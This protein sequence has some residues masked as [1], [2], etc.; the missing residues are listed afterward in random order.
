M[1]APQGGLGLS[2][3]EGVSL[4]E[5]R[6]YEFSGYGSGGFFNGVSTHSCV[7]GDEA[8]GSNNRSIRARYIGA[9]F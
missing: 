4:L 6:L 5:A 1:S 7:L 2:G 3:L 8:Q 9:A